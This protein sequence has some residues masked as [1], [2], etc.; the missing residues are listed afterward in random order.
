VTVRALHS[1]FEAE[2][3]HIDVGQLRFAA[4]LAKALALPPDPGRRFGEPRQARCLRRQ[5][6]EALDQELLG[7]FGAYRGCLLDVRMRE[8]GEACGVD[9]ILVDRVESGK[10]A[11]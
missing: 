2:F 9:R 11:A 8:L 3:A 7:F 6:L 1:W 5:Q 10:D 4:L